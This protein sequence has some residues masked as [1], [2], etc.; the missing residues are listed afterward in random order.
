MEPTK[1][2]RDTEPIVL[3]ERHIR[4]L[5]EHDFGVKGLIAHEWV[6]PF[7]A[8]RAIGPLI[9]VHDGIFDP[10]MGIGHHPHRFNER[11]FY[12]LEGAVDHDDALNRIQGHMSTGDLGRLTEG[13][14]GMFH[15]EWNNTA[16]R[17]RAFILVY[18]TDPVPERASFELLAD[19]E[20]PR[21]ESAPGVATKELVGSR[22]P[23]ELG[24]D[25]RSF[26]D[27]VLTPGA[28]LIAPLGQDEGGLVFPLEGEVVIDGE[29]VRPEAMVLSPPT[30]EPR[31][32]T[33]VAPGGARILRATFGP[34]EGLVRV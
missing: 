9:M 33:L 32:Q 29:A 26:T 24:G 28:E 30:R 4:V 17:A 6:G 11:L 34:G 10:H 2:Q 18:T 27:D 5:G 20:A 1:A 25:V 3:T 13:R 7:V 15:K 19:P 16:G 22:S 23:L 21:Y 14:I 8:L 31:T 12:I